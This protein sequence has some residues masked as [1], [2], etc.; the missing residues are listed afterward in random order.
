[1]WEKKFCTCGLPCRA[2]SIERIEPANRATWQQKRIVG[3]RE[4]EAAGTLRPGQRVQLEIGLFLF[5]L[6]SGCI[7]PRTPGGN[8]TPVSVTPVLPGVRSL[9]YDIGA[10]FD[11]DS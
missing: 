5:A 1:M 11:S 4:P 7:G 2:L 8:R 10:A 9:G 3:A 6:G